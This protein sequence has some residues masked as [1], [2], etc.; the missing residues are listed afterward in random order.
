MIIAIVGTT[1]SG[2]SDLGLYLAKK[3]NGEI[4]CA[5]SC[6]IYRGMDIGTAKPSA[7]DQ[8]LVPDHLLDIIEPGEKLGAAEFKRLAAIAEAEILARGNIPFLVGGSGMYVDAILYDYDFPKTNN[9]VLR[10]ILDDMTI[11]ELCAKLK[12]IDFDAYQNIDLH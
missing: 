11:Q 10:S 6:T 12:E 2:K 7:K 4:I 5:D 8:R 9:A 3:Y 1:A